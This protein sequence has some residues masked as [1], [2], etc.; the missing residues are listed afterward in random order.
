MSPRPAYSEL[1]NKVCLVCT[2][3]TMQDVVALV[4]TISGLSEFITLLAVQLSDKIV[5]ARFD[6]FRY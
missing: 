4:V 5:S 2:T 3:W 1:V 6:S